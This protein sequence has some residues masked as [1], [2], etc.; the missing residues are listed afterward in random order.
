LAATASA[1]SWKQA[2]MDFSRRDLLVRAAGAVVAGGANAILLEGCGFGAPNA[3]QNDLRRLKDWSLV[4]SPGASVLEKRDLTLGSNALDVV[5][6]SNGSEARLICQRTA[7]ISLT[8]K[9]LKLWLKIDAATANNLLYVAVKAGAGAVAFQNFAYEEIVA[10]GGPRTA[11]I[12]FL[13]STI[14]P[15]EW[16]PITLGPASLVGLSAS[17]VAPVDFDQI[18]DFEL[19]VAA[20]PG[21]RAMLGFG[22]ADIVQ[23][24]KRYPRGVVSITFDDG[25]ASP[26]RLARPLLAKRG[27]PAT[28]YVIR[29]LIRPEGTEGSYMSESELHDLQRLGW[30]IAAHANLAADHNAYL[31]FVTL[32]ADR[33]ISDAEQEVAWLRASGFN[34]FRDTALP[35][36]WFDRTVLERLVRY[37]RFQTIR[38]VDFRTVETLPVADPQRLRARLYDRTQRVGPASAPGSLQWRVDAI[39]RYGGWLILGFHD[40]VGPSNPPSN[41]P[42]VD[43]GSA[44]SAADFEKLVAYI[45]QRGVPVRTVGEVWQSQPGPA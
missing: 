3:E 31:G 44:I 2:M 43:E 12:S 40:M 37:G 41:A 32:P 35:Q 13:L 4:A 7:P 11:N 18:Q 39:A 5:T 21:K 1:V 16:T 8:N 28:A 27:L 26:Y 9:M 33:L 25:L 15:G 6:A 19:A 23:G 38:T 45:H 29:D 20:M 30:E 36:G 34:G 14:K 24:D 42:I 22:G 10:T 17:N